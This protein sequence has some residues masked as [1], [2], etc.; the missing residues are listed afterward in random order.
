MIRPCLASS[1][2]E[3]RWLI[4]RKPT[5]SMPRDRASPKCWIET[6]AS[7]QWVA[8]RATE[9]PASRALRRSSIVP[10]PGTS[11]TAIIACVA[12]SAAART[13]VMSSTLEKP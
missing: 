7:V 2:G 13:R 8:I 6:S 1:S 4:M 5:V 3:V 11:S 10:M 12:S 9:A